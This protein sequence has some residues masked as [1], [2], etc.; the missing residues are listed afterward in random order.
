M[1]YRIRAVIGLG[2]VVIDHPR[3]IL[4][5]KKNFPVS[6]KGSWSMGRLR[7]ETFIQLLVTAENRNE[8]GY[9]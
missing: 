7:M 8:N 6:F 3:P 2:R 4:M 5:D 1:I 9:F